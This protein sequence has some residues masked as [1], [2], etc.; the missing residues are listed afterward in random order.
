MI[1]WAADQS[2]IVLRRD[3]VQMGVDDNALRRAVDAGALVRIRQGAYVLAPV[4]QQANPAERHSLLVSAVRALYDENV[5]AS[6]VS[7]CVEYGGPTWGMD[8]SSVHLTSLDGTAHRRSARVVHHRGGLRVGDLTRDASGWI[9]APARTALDTASLLPQEP[10]VA[11]LDWYLQQG[12]ATSDQID[13]TF[14]SMRW[15]PD[16]LGLRRVVQLADGRAESVGETRTRLLCRSERLPAPIPQF[17]IRHPSGRIAGRVDFAWPERR[18]LLE[19]D[20]MAKYHRLRRPGESIEQAVMREKHREDLLREL[21]GWLM[22]RLIWADLD[23]PESTAA[24]IRRCFDMA[25]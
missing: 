15:W 5:A 25:A 16:T 20:G 2:G 13:H 4:W 19:F 10:G 23:R 24:R 22:I 21:T 8:L 3:A 6:H 18:T 17:E 14:A 1:D 7:A 9:T 11:V 12:L